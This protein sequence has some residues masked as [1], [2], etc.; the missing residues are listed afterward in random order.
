MLRVQQKTGTGKVRR[1]TGR[2]SLVLW[3][4]KSSLEDKSFEMEE[5]RERERGEIGI[6]QVEWRSLPD[7][8]LL[9][10]VHYKGN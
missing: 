8:T 6:F 3:V 7:E 9:I 4:I 2:R 10:V 5:W 1:W